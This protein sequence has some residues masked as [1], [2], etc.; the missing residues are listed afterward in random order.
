MNNEGLN[1][2]FYPIYENLIDLALDANGLCVVK[3]VISKYQLGDQKD[4]I[5]KT[6]QENVIELAQSPYGNYALQEA[7]EHW[8]LQ[9]CE[10][11]YQVLMKNLLQLSMQ[12]FSSNVIETCLDKA[13][14]ELKYKFAERIC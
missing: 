9:D 2:I 3:I 13:N 4:M 12:K 7:M 8:S 5:L 1:Y 11:I 10:E 6:I 14:N